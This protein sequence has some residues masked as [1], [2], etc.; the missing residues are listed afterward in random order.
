MNNKLLWSMLAFCMTIMLCMTVS[1]CGGDDTPVRSTDDINPGGN[2]SDGSGTFDINV[3]K[4]KLLGTWKTTYEEGYTVITF[5]ESGTAEWKELYDGKVDRWTSTYEIS[6]EYLTI[7]TDDETIK[8]PYKLDAMKLTFDEEE[9]LKIDNYV[10]EDDPLEEQQQADNQFNNRGAVATQFRGSGTKSNPYIISDASELRKLADDVESG[11]TYRDEYFK[12]T[13]D[14]IINSNV[15]SADGSLVGNVATLEQ[16]KP[17]GKGLVPFCGTFDG[18]GHSISGLFIKKENRDSLGLFG[19]FAG[20][21]SN[22]TIKD[23][24]IEGRNKLGS[25][26][27]AANVVSY[28]TSYS[29]LVTLC[30]NHG[31]VTSDITSGIYHGGIAGRMDRG[32]IKKC[33]N[34]GKIIGYKDVGGILGCSAGNQ[35]IDVANFGGINGYSVIGGVIGNS[36]SSLKP[37]ATRDYIYNCYNNGVI[38]SEN[39]H[40]GGIIALSHSITYI[41]NIV[42]YGLLRTSNEVSIGALIGYLGNERH[43][44]NGY[45]LETSYPE[46]F[47]H[48]SGTVTN[49]KSMTSN[50]M[51]AQTFLN[52]LNENAKALGSSY[53]Q[54]KFGKNGYPILSWIEE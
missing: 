11:K 30:I 15:I 34:Y 37:H 29:P 48:I 39:G 5:K 45:F 33:A 46:P 27:G 4:Q 13:A 14:I 50:Q 22:L 7:T 10:D 42:N 40:I 47:G 23:S 20:T 24:Y 16:W 3:I 32:T 44:S 28:S 31:T 49:V 18:N 38:S 36:S 17:I 43:F 54:W 19:Y 53:S 25:F 8:Y 35:V 21:L 2:S 26:V 52:E 9:Y 1:S 6:V 51:K 12:M 41:D